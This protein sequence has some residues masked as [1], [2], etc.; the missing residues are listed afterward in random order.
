MTQF[1]FLIEYETTTEKNK[2]A[3]D[4]PFVYKMN[5]EEMVKKPFKTLLRNDIRRCALK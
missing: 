5:I 3:M 1:S 4:L 2:I